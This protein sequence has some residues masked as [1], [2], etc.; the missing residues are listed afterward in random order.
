MARVVALKPL[1]R[2]PTSDRELNLI[3]SHIA[4]VIRS[5]DGSHNLLQAVQLNAGPN[6]VSHGLGRAYVSWWPANY[7]TS[8]LLRPLTDAAHNPDRTK[9]VCI[10][11]SAPATVDIVVC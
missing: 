4:D 8:I 1:R 9:W 6:L 5:L 2:V 11:A 3:Q 10:Q 7:D